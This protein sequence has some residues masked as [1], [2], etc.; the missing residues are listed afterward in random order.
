MMDLQWYD[1]VG[2]AGTCMVLGAYFLLQSGWLQGRGLVYQFMN[3]L[4]AGGV[5]VSLLGRFSAPVLVLGLSWVLISAY[6][7]AR[8]YRY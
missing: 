8:T 4:G 2:F 3:L 5:L 1:W 6:G 7:I